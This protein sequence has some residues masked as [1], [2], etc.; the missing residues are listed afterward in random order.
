MQKILPWQN[1]RLHQLLTETGLA[2]E[3]KALV[4]QYSSIDSESSKDLL[5][6]EANSLIKHL[7]NMVPKK[8]DPGDVQR[9]KIISFAHKMG[10]K[11][12]ND[13]VDMARL[14]NWCKHYGRYHKK[15]NDHTLQELPYLVTQ[16]E[17]VYDTFMKGVRKW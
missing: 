12:E 4:L 13:R 2:E 16:I 1:K 8:A 6:N 5:V 14:D 7:E 15:L 9:K 17:E 11:L 10:W 3:K